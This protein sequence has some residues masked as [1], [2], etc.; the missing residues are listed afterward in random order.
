M[1]G[2]ALILPYI[3]IAVTG[4]LSFPA[5]PSLP[6]FNLHTRTKRCSCNTWM[7]K[8]CVYFC[9]LDI[10]WVNTGGQ[11][12]PYGLGN[13]PRRRKRTTPRCQCEDKGDGVCKT[14]CHQ[15]TRDIVDNKARAVN[16][17]LP[18]KPFR[19]VKKSQVNLLHALRHI[20][21]LSNLKTSHGSI[22]WFSV[23][24]DSTSWKKK[25]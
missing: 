13:P 4:V 5:P 9:H 19:K 23:S 15:T 21:A 1:Q 8:E 24:P 14:F 12:L 16:T 7:D 22:P 20:S 10:I 17:D 25:R 18:Q 11:T 2:T 6:Q 3:A